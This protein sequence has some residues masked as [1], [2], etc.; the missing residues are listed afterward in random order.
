MTATQTLRMYLVQNTGIV[1]TGLFINQ[2]LQTLGS[3]IIARLIPSP[4]VFGEVNLMQQ[5]LGMSGLFLN[6]GLNSALTYLVSRHGKKAI[7]VSF[8]VALAGSAAVGLLM[9]CV[10]TICAPFLASSYHLQQLMIALFVGSFILIFNSLTN[11]GIATFSGMRRF[12]SQTI[13]MVATTLFS[14]TGTVFGVWFSDRGSS[15]LLFVAA[16]TAVASALTSLVVLSTVRKQYDLSVWV[17]IRRKTLGSMLRYGVPMWA[18]NI[19][20]AFQQPFLV[21]IT[22]ATSVVAAGYLS[23]G[24]KI[25]GFLNIITWAFNVV[26]LPFLSEVAHDASQASQRGTMC[27][28][29]NNYI[30]FPLTL[31]ICAFPQ[32][33]TYALFGSKYVTADAGAYARLLALGVL[34]SSIGRLGGTML[35][36][37]GRTRANFWVMVVSGAIVFVLVPIVTRINPLYGSFVYMCGWALSAVSL[38][39]FMVRDGLPLH[40]RKAFVEPLLPSICAAVFLMIGANLKSLD[41]YTLFIGA[42]CV[43]FIT[44]L[45][46]RS[47]TPGNALHRQFHHI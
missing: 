39:W 32:Q 45:M 37:M 10:V 1:L 17:R 28:R 43:L 26:S 47:Y 24:L 3:G 14:T 36:G 42:V 9:A 11:V 8:H 34:F 16:F 13:L 19:A 30:L 20:K 21:M 2:L 22:G 4:A 23:N 18:G 40:W 5:I 7:G 15:A 27:F 12:L 44:W 33:L 46:E 25:A 31:F 38:F 41:V 29:Y 6:M 35:G